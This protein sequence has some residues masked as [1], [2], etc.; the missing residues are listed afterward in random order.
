MLHIFLCRNITIEY[1]ASRLFVAFLFL[2]W[3]E[4]ELLDTAVVNG[5]FIL[6]NMTYEYIILMK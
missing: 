5:P 6:T 1:N 4:S 2:K 3:V